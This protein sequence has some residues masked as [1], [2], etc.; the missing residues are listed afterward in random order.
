MSLL[1]QGTESQPGARAWQ[2]SG[3]LG[4]DEVGVSG[5]GQT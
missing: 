1:V 2:A 4:Q 5:I 3:T